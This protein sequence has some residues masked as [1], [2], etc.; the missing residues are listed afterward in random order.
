MVRKSTHGNMLGTGGWF[1]GWCVCVGGW[2]RGVGCVGV[3]MVCGY[4]YAWVKVGN[5]GWPPPSSGWLVSAVCW[6]IGAGPSVVVTCYVPKSPSDSESDIANPQSVVE[7]SSEYF[8]DKAY[9][10]L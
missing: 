10:H 5:G 7:K 6:Q 8:S 2:V 3:R 1:V 4:Y 9:H